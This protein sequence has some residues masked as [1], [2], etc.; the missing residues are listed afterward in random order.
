MEK[1]N[2]RPMYVESKTASKILNTYEK[3][4]EARSLAIQGITDASQ[5]RAL[6][7]DRIELA[8]WTSTV[9]KPLSLSIG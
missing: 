5:Y 8:P 4:L 7:D 9:I 3:Y 6:I 2:G 1:R